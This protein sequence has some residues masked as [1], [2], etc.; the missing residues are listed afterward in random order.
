MVSCGIDIAAKRAVFVF[1]KLD[2]SVS[3]VT[4]AFTQLRVRDDDDPGALSAFH[5]S[6]MTM[7]AARRPHRIGILQRKKFG[8]F[9]ASGTT[10]KLEALLQL[11]PDQKVEIVSGQELRMFAKERQPAVAPRYKYQKNAYLLA[12]YLLGSGH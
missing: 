5:R 12:L 9:A 8:T 2:G 4:G 10:F 11:Y 7:F 1:L 6:A 3:D